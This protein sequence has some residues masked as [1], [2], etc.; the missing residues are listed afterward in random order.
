[1][2]G[3]YPRV[4]GGTWAV[5]VPA[6]VGEGLSPRGRGNRIR[7]DTEGTK[8]KVYPRVGGGTA[9]PY[10]ELSGSQGLSPRGRG[11]LTPCGSANTK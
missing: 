9:Y 6:S 5:K 3:V 1:M 8:T 10:P 7:N 11:N 2:A 4:D